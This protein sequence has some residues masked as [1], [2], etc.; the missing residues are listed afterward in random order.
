VHVGVGQAERIEAIEVLWPDGL[1]ERF[2]GGPVD[3][4][5][6]LRRGEGT[7]GGGA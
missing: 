1:R 3:R 6:E 5:I 4:Q 7:A 2:D